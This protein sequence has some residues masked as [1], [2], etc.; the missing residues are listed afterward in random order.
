[1]NNE[2][3]PVITKGQEFSGLVAGICLM[4]IIL[5]AIVILAA[6]IQ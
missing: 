1:M 2:N 3:R 6:H 4:A 5:I